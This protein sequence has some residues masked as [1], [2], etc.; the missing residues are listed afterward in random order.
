MDKEYI[1]A[2]LPETAEP[3]L[4]NWAAEIAWE[5]LGGDFTIFARESIELTEG[6]EML[7]TPESRAEK[8]RRARRTWAAFCSC[9]AC[10]TEFYT[11][12]AG[13]HGDKAAIFALTGEDGCTYDGWCEAGMDGVQIWAED[14]SFPCPWC[15]T[16]TRLIRRSRLRQG[17]SYQTMAAEIRRVG[18]RGEYTALVFWLLR[19]EVSEWGEG[20]VSIRPREAIVLDE[21]GRR[22]R[23]SHSHIGQK[24]EREAEHWEH[25]TLRDPEQI[26]YYSYGNG[27][28]RSTVGAYWRTSVPDLT[29]STG[30]KTGL[31]EYVRAHGAFPTVYL[32]LWQRQPN[33]ENLIKAG[34]T[35]AISDEV[36]EQSYRAL[37]YGGNQLSAEIEG[38][39]WEEAKPHRMLRMSKEE[40]RQI[41]KPRWNVKRFN[42]WVEFEGLYGRRASALSL[43]D[44]C[45]RY[46]ESAVALLL[47]ME[48]DGWEDFDLYRVTRYLDRQSEIPPHMRG[49][50]YA[51]YRE[52]LDKQAGETALTEIELYPP[53]L[54]AAHDR[55]ADSIK[56]DTDKR[57]AARFAE[58]KA[59]YKDLEWTDGVF[60]IVVPESNAELVAEG[61]TLRHC[62]GGYGQKHCE[63][64]PIFFVRKY[65]TP[66]R[67]YFTLN[68]NLKGDEAKRIQLHGYGNEFARGKQ[69]RIPEEVQR[70]VERW[71]REVL[72]PW[73]SARQ[74]A[75]RSG[76]KKKKRRAA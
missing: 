18:E 64:Q 21:Q 29:G 39:S 66:G 23:F 9:T 7:E 52:M 20:G 22:W 27:S 45:E 24:G 44:W 4:K 69:L 43:Q 34:W 13:R 11:G 61:R 1:R 62:V 30:E 72:A 67:S 10:G 47:G 38:V 57:R 51:D 60:R 71:E 41:N 55:L 63:G 33:V 19:R 68:E 48:I 16:Q 2:S 53:D 6:A 14:E 15:G 70:F 58:L 46:T 26:K 25:R 54:R 36:A 76:N 50:M 32:G 8:R 65:R 3:G 40:F 74:K 35:E 31:A 75:A 49:Q 5:D 17:R 73:H 37:S 56:C 42:L 28:A 12:W 59:L